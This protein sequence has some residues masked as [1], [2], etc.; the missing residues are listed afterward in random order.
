MRPSRFPQSI[1][2]KTMAARLA[3]EAEERAAAEEEARQKIA[4]QKAA[5]AAQKK[6]EVEAADAARREREREAELHSLVRQRTAQRMM[7]EKAA[8]E[9]R[10]RVPV[11]ET[12]YSEFHRHDEM[13]FPKGQYGDHFT[14]EDAT[15]VEGTPAGEY[16][17]EAPGASGD[18]HPI[19]PLVAAMRGVPEGTLEL[20]P[21]FKKKPEAAVV[22]KGLPRSA[23]LKN[24]EHEAME[25]QLI[26][27]MGLLRGI[28]DALTGKVK[29]EGGQTKEDMVRDIYRG[30]LYKPY[31]H[32]SAGKYSIITQLDELPKLKPT[33]SIGVRLLHGGPGEVAAAAR[34]LQEDMKAFV[35]R[36]KAK[37]YEDWMTS[38]KSGFAGYGKWIQE[39]TKGMKKGALTDEAKRHGM[40]PLEFAHHVLAHPK[41][42]TI[43]TRR[44][45]QFAVNVQK[46]H[47]KGGDL[48]SVGQTIADVGRNVILPGINQVIPG[49]GTVLQKTGDA[50]TG[51]FTPQ[52][53]IDAYNAQQ[54]A[55]A[56]SRAQIAQQYADATERAK[57]DPYATAKYQM[58][59]PNNASRDQI[60]DAMFAGMGKAPPSL[61]QPPHRFRRFHAE[62]YLD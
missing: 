40:E 6:R 41:D 46:R 48:N 14:F 57:T 26:S 50:I 18:F 61:R 2:E 29:P 59:L 31:W 42:F 37:G 24:E 13:G 54:A 11:D 5:I 20:A 38:M 33:G 3:A 62:E 45:A 1:R 23:P 4:R 10:E 47:L 22:E 55:D 52:A 8:F 28:G 25:N 53:D 15:G 34:D 19:P 56:A 60:A 9:T 32:G 49:L 17:S 21:R 36:M 43:T 51:L 30:W 58:G 27:M 39:A 7:R 44:R 16:P 12:P 35:K